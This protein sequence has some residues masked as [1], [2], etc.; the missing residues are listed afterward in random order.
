VQKEGTD[1]IITS[2]D[3]HPAPHAAAVRTVCLEFF[4][5]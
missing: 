1:G 2:A 5:T 4:G 3:V